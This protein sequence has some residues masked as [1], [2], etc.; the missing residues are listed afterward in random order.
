L[1]RTGDAPARTNSRPRILLLSDRSQGQTRR[2]RE[3]AD[4]VMCSLS[5]VI[6]VR[7]RFLAIGMQ[8]ALYDEGWPGAKP[9][10]TGKVE[11]QLT[12][13]ACSEAPDGAAGWTLRLLAEQMIELGYV[14]YISHV[15]VRELLKRNELQP[16]RVK[17]W[18]IGKPS[19]S[20]LAKMEDVLEVYQRPY[21]PKRPVVCLDDA[22]KELHATPRGSLP[23]K[24]GKPL[25]EHYEYERHGVA[26][27]FLAIQ[28]L[29]GR[30]KVRVAD[31][32]AYVYWPD[33]THVDNEAAVN[34]RMRPFSVIA[35][36]TIPAGG[37]EGVRIAQGGAFAGWSL[38]VKDGRLICEHKYVGLERYRVASTETIPEGDLKLGLEFRITG[39]FEITPDLTKMGVQGVKSEPVLDINERPVGRGEI[40]KTVPFGRSLS[41][42]AC[43]AGTTAKRP[44]A[45]CTSR[46]IGSPGRSIAWWSR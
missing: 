44:S 34:V 22:S 10:F 40:S 15:T 18:C 23:L 1:I 32:Q 36:A 31:W 8:S 11:A 7:R 29:C 21:I 27:E 24:P 38:F 20:Y 25:R 30:R 2:D 6:N 17:S 41:A 45:G 28:P 5:S 39:A 12:M 9:K 4:A 14:D 26:N 13:L 42:K 3:V 35:R 37:A 46:R 33:T 16:W 19:G 43:A